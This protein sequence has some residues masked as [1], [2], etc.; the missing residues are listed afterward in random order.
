[1]PC[2][3]ARRTER[4]AWGLIQ[5]AVD[6]R[7]SGSFAVLEQLPRRISCSLRRQRREAFVTDS[8]RGPGPWWHRRRNVFPTH[9]ARLPHGFVFLARGS[10][11]SN[12]T[13]AVVLA[14]TEREG[15]RALP[16]G[17]GGFAERGCGAPRRLRARIV[18]ERRSGR[19]RQRAFLVVEQLRFGR[20]EFRRRPTKAINFS[21]QAWRRARHRLGRAV[22]TALHKAR[23]SG[24]APERAA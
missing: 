12:G 24:F 4:D 17:F 11:V 8:A 22:E 2:S 6:A 13:L 7:G 20:N 16:G 23:R 10:F 19:I 14:R 21:S 1:V 18:L 3:A 5:L 9:T 15:K